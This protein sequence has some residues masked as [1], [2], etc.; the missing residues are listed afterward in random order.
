MVT[1]ASRPL[2]PPCDVS[3]LLPPLHR[4]NPKISKAAALVRL[5]EKAGGDL[6]LA[7]VPDHL[8][9]SDDT[10]F[11]VLFRDELIDEY[12]ND[13][14]LTSTKDARNKAAMARQAAQQ[15]DQ[16]ALRLAQDAK[17]PYKDYVPPEDPEEKK[18][19][20]ERKAAAEAEAAA[21]AARAA[22]GEDVDGDENGDGEGEDDG[23]PEDADDN[24]D[25]DDTPAT[26][27]EPVIPLG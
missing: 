7:A 12:A 2:A 24:D 13:M 1:D 27:P 8:Q 6:H 25:D 5:V 4:D 10:P 17:V 3:L 16:R 20:E 15:A 18:R 21:R 14:Q 11:R 22:A 26:P 23:D 19:E 9:G